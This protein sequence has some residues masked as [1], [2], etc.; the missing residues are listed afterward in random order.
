MFV[1]IHSPLVGPATWLKVAH[2]LEAQSFDVAVPLLSDID[3]T[4]RAYW[5]QHADAVQRALLP[6]PDDRHLILVGHSGAGPLLPVIR[7][8]LPHP[9]AAYVFADAGLPQAGASRLDLIASEAPDWY[10]S[11]HAF[12]LAGGRFPDWRAEDL[13]AEIPDEK[14]R[15]SLLS[16]LQPRALPFWT[17]PIP[18]SD[19]WPDAACAYLQFSPAYDASAAQ[20]R[21]RGWPY[22]HLSGGHFLPLVDPQA[23]AQALIQLW[24]DLNIDPAA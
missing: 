10:P 15:N 5:Q 19:G 9:I 4:D 22:R 21:D 16:E 11:F 17:E 3:S 12:L 1:L 23:V 6:V 2:E 24:R 13:I 18:V 20:A 8:Q 7:R 14:L